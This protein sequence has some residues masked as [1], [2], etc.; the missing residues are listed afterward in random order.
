M[1]FEHLITRK[2]TIYIIARVFFECARQLVV[3]MITIEYI[4]FSIQMSKRAL[5]LRKIFLT[6]I[7]PSFYCR[8]VII[9]IS[10]N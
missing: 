7:L 9:L 2:Y 6:F 1:T 10:A 4:H 3:D 5:G 8:F